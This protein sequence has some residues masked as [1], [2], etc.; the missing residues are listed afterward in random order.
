M[1]ALTRPSTTFDPAQLNGEGGYSLVFNRM[2]LLRIGAA[3]ARRSFTR[4]ITLTI[5]SSAAS[6]L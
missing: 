1:S 6:V 5:W 2:S 4:S 3:T